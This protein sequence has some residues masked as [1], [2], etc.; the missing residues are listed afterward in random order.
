MAALARQVVNSA[1]HSHQLSAYYLSLSSRINTVGID[2]NWLA[3]TAQAGLEVDCVGG[4]T[5]VINHRCACV[6]AIAHAARV[7]AG[8][9]WGTVLQNSLHV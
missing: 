8:S 2:P 3:T 9:D 4:G 5:I 7:L 6:L 1:F